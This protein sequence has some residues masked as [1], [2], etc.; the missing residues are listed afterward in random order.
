MNNLD[1]YWGGFV[2]TL[3]TCVIALLLSFVLGFLIAIMRVSTVGWMRFISRWYVEFLRNTPLLV[4]VFIFYYALPTLEI[5][6]LNFDGFQAG[7][8][9]L[10]F[11]T[12]AYI[13]ENIRSGIQS[14][15]SGQ[16]EAS[17]SSGLSYLQSMIFIILP[18]AFRIA[19]PPLGNQ[20]INLIKNSA[21]LAFF[22]GGDIMYVA[23]S[24]QSS[25]AVFPVYITAGIFYLI[26][27]IPMSVFVNFLER[28]LA[29]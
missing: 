26:L 10:T 22:A 14:V 16:L 15:P 18:Q 28:K 6:W 21:V 17:R 12:A 5:D 29:V 2:T 25:G 8:L 27:T 3:T 7:M 11:Y 1:L 19:T 20:F 4:Q 23:D 9:G 13:A 24:L